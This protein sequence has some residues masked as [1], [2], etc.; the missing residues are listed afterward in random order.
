MIGDVKCKRSVWL[1]STSSACMVPRG[2]G[3]GLPVTVDTRGASASVEGKF[4]YEPPTI[5]SYHPRNGPPRGGF[6]VTITGRNFGHVDTQ[7][8]AYLAGRV[9]METY[10][11][12][13]R[14]VLCR[15]P[16][17]V[18]GSA[19]LHTV[20]VTFE[21][22]EHVQVI[23]HHHLSPYCSRFHASCCSLSLPSLTHSSPAGH[24][25]QAARHRAERGAGARRH[26]IGEA[27]RG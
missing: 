17:G 14:K 15:G 26:G 12:S 21:P 24:A 19:M 22:A 8:T 1:S 16:P 18:G 3:T 9:C 20:D 2:M 5:D 13:H 27:R 4:T 7:P 10:W 11:M 6:W 25:A 23:C